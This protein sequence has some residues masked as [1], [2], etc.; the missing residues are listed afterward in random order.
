MLSRPKILVC[1]D[2]STS[3]DEALKAAEKIRLLTHG[4][5]HALHVLELN[6]AWDW[7]PEAEGGPKPISKKS[8]GDLLSS[9]QKRLEDQLARNKV[10]GDG[11]ILTGLPDATIIQQVIDQK[12]DLVIMSHKGKFESTFVVGSLPEKVIAFCPVPLLIIKKPFESPKVAALVDP[13]GDLTTALQWAEDISLLFSSNIT[14]IS[15]FPDVTYHYANFLKQITGPTLPVL[16]PEQKNNIVKAITENLRAKITKHTKPH[17]RVE[18]NEEKKV[19]YHLNSI[20]VDEHIDL[21]VM[22]R[23]QTNLLEKIFIGSET[24][25]LLDL[26]NGNLFILPP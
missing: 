18:I 21:A 20:L 23:H 6:V 26:Y 12:I 10:R 13:N 2:F 14:A 11:H 15:L 16:T 9:L 7:M 22:K 17:I 8:E 1:S 25:R 3:S 19:A 5:L 24:R 4:T